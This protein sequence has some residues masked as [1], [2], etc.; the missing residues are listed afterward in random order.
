MRLPDYTAHIYP[1]DTMNTPAQ[2]LGEL[3]K[4]NRQLAVEERRRQDALADAQ[5]NA[6]AREK[7]AAVTAFF[8][9]ARETFVERILAGQDAGEVLL[10]SR[11]EPKV[12]QAL[13]TYRWNDPRS[14]IANVSHA[15]H[16]VWKDFAGW[17]AENGL[18]PELEYQHDGGGMHSWHALKVHPIA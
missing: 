9:K 1:E 2:T 6:E 4:A 12:C 10:D 15:Y 3:L 17:A 8:D 18:R 16:F 7:L 11:R 13:A 14:T 5:R